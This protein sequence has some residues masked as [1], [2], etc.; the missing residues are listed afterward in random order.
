MKCYDNR[1][2]G[3]SDGHY[4]YA[5]GGIELLGEFVVVYDDDVI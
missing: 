2:T 3:E 4:Y 1:L 5:S